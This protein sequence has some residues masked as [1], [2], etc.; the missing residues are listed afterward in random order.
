MTKRLFL[1]LFIF[2]VAATAVQ[3]QAPS[4]TCTNELTPLELD[5]GDGIPLPNS[6][7]NPTNR[8]VEFAAVMRANAFF[9]PERVVSKVSLPPGTGRTMSEVC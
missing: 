7:S 3:A 8:T 1:V 2:Q 4:A 5:L 9:G 6:Y